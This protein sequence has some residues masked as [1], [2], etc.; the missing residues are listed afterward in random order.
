MK[1]RVRGVLVAGLMLAGLQSSPAAA[2]EAAPEVPANLEVP[3]GHRAFLRAYA[4]GTQNYVCLETAAGVSWRF[5]GPQATLFYPILGFQQQVTT[6]FLSANPDEGGLARPTWQHSFDSSRVW[7][8]SIASSSDPRYV[9]AGAIPWLLLQAA[10]TERGPAGGGFLA[11]TSYIQRVS[12]SGGLAPST[13]CGQ[14]SDVG[15]V[16]LVPYSTD[17]VFFRANR[18]AGRD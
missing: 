1:I 18:G 8:R 4:V 15:A 17:Y 14:R 6:H 16:A 13:G 12:T 7:G 5:I 3:A 9:E 2:R 11:S 10:G